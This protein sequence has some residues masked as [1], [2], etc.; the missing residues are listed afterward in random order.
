M[1]RNLAVTV[2][3][4]RGAFSRPLPLARGAKFETSKNIDT[5]VNAINAVILVWRIVEPLVGLFILDLG[6]NADEEIFGE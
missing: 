6:K 5:A 4:D 3:W 1:L 2:P